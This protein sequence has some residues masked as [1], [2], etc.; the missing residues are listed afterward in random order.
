[1][2]E[3]PSQLPPAARFRQPYHTE[4]PDVRTVEANPSATGE[5]T[6]NR[7]GQPS[8]RGR[9]GLSD[10]RPS[11]FDERR[12]YSALGEGRVAEDLRQ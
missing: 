11:P 3:N 6:A 10:A 7:P 2:V 12:V 5:P 9:E 4:R 8:A 1:V